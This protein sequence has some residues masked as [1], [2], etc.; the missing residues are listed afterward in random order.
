MLYLGEVGQRESPHIN[1][2]RYL[3]SLDLALVADKSYVEEFFL[4]PDL[5]ESYADVRLEVRPRQ[6]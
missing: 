4:F 1:K 3:V 6:T 2:V 5:S